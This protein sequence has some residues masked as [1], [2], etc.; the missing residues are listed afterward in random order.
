M[1][2]DLHQACLTTEVLIGDP[3]APCRLHTALGWT[4][5][6]RAVGD[7]RVFDPPKVMINF[8]NC[9]VVGGRRNNND[10]CEQILELLTQD[11]KNYDE[12][13]GGPMK[14]Q[15]NK[16]ALA[17]LNRTTKKENDHYFVGLLWK[18]DEPMHGVGWSS[19]GGK[20][21]KWTA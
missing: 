15:N 19:F 2:C 17:V 21:F 13:P 10:S 4:I 7:K 12:P 5:Y 3:G 1:G 14:S 9:L 16:Q 11:L 18:D 20:A 6:G 8:M